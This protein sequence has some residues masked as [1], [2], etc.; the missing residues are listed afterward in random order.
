VQSDVIGFIALDLVLGFILA[1]VVPVAFV[2]HV[3]G[4]HL[5]DPAADPARLR[6]P[7]YAVTSLESHHFGVGR[8]LGAFSAGACL[9]FGGGYA[10]GTSLRLC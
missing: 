7:T 10:A 4:V 1:R 8:L 9:S 3:L 6:V 5:D 2:I